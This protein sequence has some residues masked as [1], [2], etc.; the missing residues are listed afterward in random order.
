MIT[1]SSPQ[2]DIVLFVGLD[3]AKEKHDICLRQGF[4]GPAETMQ[5]KHTPEAL[6]HWME[7]LQQRARGGRIRIALEQSCGGLLNF[8]ADQPNL[9]ICLPNPKTISRL[10]D[11]FKPSGAKDD[12]TDAAILCDI[13][14]F[15]A[16]QC[17]KLARES[18]AMQLLRPLTERRRALVDDRTALVLRLQ[19]ELSRFYPQALALFKDH[20][21]AEIALAFLGKHPTLAEAQRARPQALREFFYALRSRSEKLI[22]QRITLIQNAKPLTANPAIIKAGRL[23]VIDLVRRIRAVQEGIRRGHQRDL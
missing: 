7:S 14:R 16:E 22:Q 13:S 19:E 2:P 18:E 10:R 8:L 23:A 3:W 21:E 6:A 15:H 4:N 9:E 5:I 12:P 11:A 17:P 1:P 20:L